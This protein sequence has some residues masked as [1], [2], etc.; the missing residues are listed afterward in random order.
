MIRYLGVLA[1]TLGLIIVV[2]S[3]HDKMVM[4]SSAMTL[5]IFFYITVMILKSQL[6]TFKI[7]SVLFLL[8]FYGAAYMLFT[9][10][11]LEYMPLVQKV[12][13]L[14]KIIWV[15]GLHYGTSKTDFAFI[16]K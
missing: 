14:I 4:L 1:T 16:V 6:T 5:R 9:E 2:P 8:S 11:S 7:L 3:L 10:T 12:I 13:F 15:L